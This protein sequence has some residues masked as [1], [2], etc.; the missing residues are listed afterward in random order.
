MEIFSDQIKA[1]AKRVIK[2]KDNIQTEEATKTSVIMPFFQLLNYDVFN[3]EEFLPEFTADVGIK[4]GEKVDYGIMQNGR[5][6]ILIEAKSIQEQL[7]KHDSQLFRYFG[8]TVAKFAILTN[9]IIYRFY[10]DLEEQNKMDTTPFFEFNLFDIRDHQIIELQKFRKESFNVESIITTAAELKYT[11]EIKQFL[12]TQWEN[13]SD[14]FVTYIISDVYTGK[15][16]RQVLEKFNGIVKKTLKEFINDMLNDKLQAAIATT[17]ADAIP[18]SLEI[19]VTAEDKQSPEIIT[20]QEEIEGY[21][22]IKILLKD[23]ISA[24]RLH[25]RDNLSYFNILLD[26]SIRKWICRLSLAGNTKTIQFNDNEKTTVILNSISDIILHKEK[27]IS[28]T[29]TFF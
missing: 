8:T 9:G 15:K 27:L 1:F 19:A 5:P 23:V 21:I 12:K 22:T 11:K 17:N 16:T 25:Y 29:K 26:N 10:T 28:I 7:T 18:S 24:E 4:K 3:P 6:L 13:P 20:T 14:E 2:M